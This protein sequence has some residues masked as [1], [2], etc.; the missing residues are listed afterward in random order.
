M[1]E[2]GD[3]HQNRNVSFVRRR[4]YLSIAVKTQLVFSSTLF[5]LD[6]VPKQLK[7]GVA[8]LSWL[9][10]RRIKYYFFFRLRL[11]SRGKAKKKKTHLQRRRDSCEGKGKAI[12]NVDVA[13]S[14][15][16]LRAEIEEAKEVSAASLA[17]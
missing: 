10:G 12:K 13:V 2:R 11:P 6:R 8:V 17:P 9:R 5:D 4:R 7:T 16:C 15:A 3:T 14:C 1:D